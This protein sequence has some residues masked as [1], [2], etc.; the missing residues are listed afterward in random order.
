MTHPLLDPFRHHV[1]ATLRL[2]EHCRPLGPAELTGVTVQGTYGTVMDTLRHVLGSEAGYRF[3]LTG[4]WPEWTWAPGGS[5]TL[6]Q[7]QASAE[8]SGTFWE[9]FLAGEPRPDDLL[10]LAGPDG[11]RYQVPVGL[12]LAQVLNHGND[13]RSQV[14]TVL[15]AAGVE[16]PVVDCWVYGK[17]SGRIVPANL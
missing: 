6:D 3:R 16:P 7:L 4:G 10:P 15:T 8:E 13:H 1:W 11:G 17:L 9:G 5:A 12:V 14:C 2:I